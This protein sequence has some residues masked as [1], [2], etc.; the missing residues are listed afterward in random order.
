MKHYATIYI[1]NMQATSL[2]PHTF[3]GLTKENPDKLG[4]QE[5]EI[6]KYKDDYLSGRQFLIK[7]KGKWYENIYPS[8]LSDDFQGEGFWGFGPENFVF[9]Y[10]VYKSGKVFENNQYIPKEILR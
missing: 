8:I 7:T 3:L 5:I 1:K 4:K 2:V 6:Q 10:P 9:S